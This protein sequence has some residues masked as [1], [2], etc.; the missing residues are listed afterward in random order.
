M[1]RLHSQKGC[2]SICSLEVPKLQALDD[3]VRLKQDK[4]AALSYSLAQESYG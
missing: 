2:K 1:Q 3:S 4:I